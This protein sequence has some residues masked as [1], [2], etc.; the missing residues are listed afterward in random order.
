MTRYPGIATS[1]SVIV[2]QPL[3]QGY[4][5][6]ARAIAS[7][8]LYRYIGINTGY[9]LEGATSS[10]QATNSLQTPLH[11]LQVVLAEWLMVYAF[12]ERGGMT[13]SSVG[14]LPKPM[15]A[16]DSARDVKHVASGTRIP[17]FIALMGYLADW[18]GAVL[19]IYTSITCGDV[20][21]EAE[22]LFGSID[23]IRPATRDPASPLY[24]IYK[25]SL[26]NVTPTKLIEKLNGMLTRVTDPQ[27]TRVMLCTATEG[28]ETRPL[29]KLYNKAKTIVPPPLD[30][31]L[32]CAPHAAA[33]LPAFFTIPDDVAI[34]AIQGTI[35]LIVLFKGAYLPVFPTFGEEPVLQPVAIQAT[36][37]TLVNAITATPA[38]PAELR[39]V[40]AKAY[41]LNFAVNAQI[42]DDAVKKAFNA[43][44]KPVTSSSS[45][46]PCRY[47]SKR[48]V[49][50]DIESQQLAVYMVPETFKQ[51]YGNIQSVLSFL[52]TVDLYHDGTQT[53]VVQKNGSKVVPVGTIDERAGSI[54]PLTG[55]VSLT[56]PLS[57]GQSYWSI[58]L[59][60]EDLLAI[61]LSSTPKAR[62]AL[63]ALAALHVAGVSQF[64]DA[65]TRDIVRNIEL[66][67]VNILKTAG[68]W[69]RGP[70][71]ELV[72]PHAAFERAQS[73]LTDFI[74]GID[75][76]VV[77][78]GGKTYVSHS[79]DTTTMTYQLLEIGGRLLYTQLPKPVKIRSEDIDASS[80]TPVHGLLFNAKQM[81]LLSSLGTPKAKSALKTILAK[82]VPEVVN[83]RELCNET[84]KNVE[85]MVAWIA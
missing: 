66:Q 44:F 54:K 79:G 55:S 81:A 65:T 85:D 20:D 28:T 10:I 7:A 36:A 35:T 50:S 61:I 82:V 6:C 70:V 8:L 5:S 13:T 15:S 53:V 58:L 39:E 18:I 57:V 77:E 32:V 30:V 23:G 41:V 31:T 60:R 84:R 22:P 16:I 25:A 73:I 51:Q 3:A 33:T 59:S 42:I 64:D 38:G 63:T 4:L 40:L 12:V 78:S 52:N 62:E 76:F 69:P 74:S 56:T 83:A 75:A 17:S 68:A 14:Q 9:G 47:R 21:A 49:H 72:F 80:D 29:R 71:V 67:R 11:V 27:M 43:K 34:G 1:E 26:E 2:L 45:E 19:P 46:L 24:K 48:P 37:E